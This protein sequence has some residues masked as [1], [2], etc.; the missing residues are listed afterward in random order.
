[1][2]VHFHLKKVQVGVGKLKFLNAGP[3]VD[4]L[5]AFLIVVH[6]T[7]TFETRH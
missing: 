5:R 3:T 4:M 2:K 7:P 6:R 1:M